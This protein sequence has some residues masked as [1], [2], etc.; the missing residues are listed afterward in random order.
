MKKKRE[1]NFFLKK[2]MKKN[3]SRSIMPLKNPILS[4]DFQQKHVI[5]Y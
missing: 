4:C 2:S 1:V 5:K 3:I